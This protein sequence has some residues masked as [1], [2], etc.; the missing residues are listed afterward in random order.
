M[1]L[2]I[3]ATGFESR[4]Q[5]PAP[6]LLRVASL[7]SPST[8]QSFQN[9]IILNPT[10]TFRAYARTVVRHVSF[11]TFDS[12]R[13]ASITGATELNRQLPGADN[14]LSSRSREYYL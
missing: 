6:W 5:I 10:S 7:L 2:L 13:V 4:N 12:R 3:D 14:L 1:D 9:I 8:L 11:D